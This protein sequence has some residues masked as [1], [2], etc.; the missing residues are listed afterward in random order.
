MEHPLT[1]LERAVWEFNWGE[2]WQQ[3]VIQA[4]EGF[5][6][7]VYGPWLAIEFNLDHILRISAMV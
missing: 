7:L 3:T 2:L 5:V 4:T 6:L 1:E